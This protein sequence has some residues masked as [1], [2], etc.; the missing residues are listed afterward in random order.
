M[1]ILRAPH[2]GVNTQE[3]EIIYDTCDRCDGHGSTGGHFQSGGD[4]TD[5]IAECPPCHGTGG[6]LGFLITS[7][8]VEP[9]EPIRWFPGEHSEDPGFGQETRRAA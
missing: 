7:G 8:L 9:P 4:I 1:S 6:G 5:D 2:D 3:L